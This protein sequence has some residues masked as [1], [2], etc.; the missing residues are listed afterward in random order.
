MNIQLALPSLKKIEAENVAMPQ[1][2]A[3]ML[4]DYMLIA[5]QNLFHPERKIPEKKEEKQLQ[6]PEFVLYG[7]LITDDANIAYMEDLKAPHNTPG[8]GKRQKAIQK[9]TIF[10]GFTLSEIHHDKV[11]MLRADEKIEVRILDQ[12]NKKTRGIETTASVAAGKS[13]DPESQEIKS[14]AGQPQRARVQVTSPSADKKKLSEERK[15]ERDAR[16]N[17]VR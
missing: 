7:T 5:E 2:E 15:A 8:R 11:V 10:S 3:P 9:G 12:Q 13:P 17:K 4:A 6:K 16:R 1:P 14:A